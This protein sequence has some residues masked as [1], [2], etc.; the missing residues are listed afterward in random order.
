MGS[1]C[2]LHTIVTTRDFVKGLSAQ[3]AECRGVKEAFSNINF[4]KDMKTA[5]QILV[6]IDRLI[7][8]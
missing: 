1:K 4:V 3:K 5:V 6:P 7:V 8:K 2:H